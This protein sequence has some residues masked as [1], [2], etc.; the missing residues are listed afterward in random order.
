MSMLMEFPTTNGGGA[1]GKLDSTNVEKEEEGVPS[2]RNVLFLSNLFAETVN[3]QK[4]I[5]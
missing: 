2:T 5:S 4:A 1:E 3:T